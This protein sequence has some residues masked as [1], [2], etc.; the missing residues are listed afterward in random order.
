[1]NVLTVFKRRVLLGL[2]VPHPIMALKYCE[3]NMKLAI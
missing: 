2:F 1:M 3:G